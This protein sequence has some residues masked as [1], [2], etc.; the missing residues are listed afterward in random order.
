MTRVD[1]VGNVYVGDSYSVFKI[2]A[3]GTITTLADSEDLGGWPPE[4]SALAVDESGNVYVGA[5]HAKAGRVWRIQPENGG[6]EVIAG[7]GEPGFEGEGIPPGDARLWVSG[8]AVDRSGNVWF[9]DEVN[10]RVRVLE[11]LH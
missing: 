9:T 11:R 5:N 8:I 4:I 3:S 6:I 7:N 1:T 2:D 10:R